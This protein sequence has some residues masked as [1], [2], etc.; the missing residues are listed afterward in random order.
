MDAPRD[1][2][3]PVESTDTLRTILSAS[4]RRLLNDLGRVGRATPEV[5]RALK[6]QLASSPGPAFAALRRPNVGV[7]VRTLRDRGP[8]AR[9]SARLGPTLA[10]ELWAA[11][12]SLPPLTFESPSVACLGAG[13]VL[14]GGVVTIAEGAWRVDGQALSLTEPAEELPSVAP[15]LRLGLVDDNPLAMDE[16]HPDKAGNA[17][18]LGGRPVDEWLASLRASLATIAEHM[19]LLREEMSL[20]LQQIVP[21]GFD[22]RAHL[23]ASYQEAIGT[24]YLSLHPSEMTMTEALVHEMSHN[25]LNAL[26]ELDPLLE[27]AF[28]PLYTSPVRPD[29]RPLHGILLAVHAFLPIEA[30]YER[31]IEA[32]DPRADS[33][34]FE[35]RLG[36]IRQS[37][38]QGAEVLLENAV[39]TEIGAGVLDE[40]RRL[41]SAPDLG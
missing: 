33:P 24:V 27:N 6:T 8:D 19:P 29:P 2:T 38:R 37:N 40:I 13:R 9:L 28:S 22:E 20:V 17:V 10:A 34:D 21:V 35:R 11:G 5:L 12:A 1:I 31:M 39:P 32:G 7:L 36:Q 26:F 18:D 14:P 23:S 25:K 30:L 41:S 3:V 16:A 15:G 4:L